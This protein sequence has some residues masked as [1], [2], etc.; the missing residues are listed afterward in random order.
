MI[1]IKTE[2]GRYFFSNF[3]N[4]K[5]NESIE[6][7][8]DS[9]G[10]DDLK[11]LLTAILAGRLVVSEEDKVVVERLASAPATSSSVSSPSLLAEDEKIDEQYIPYDK[12]LEWLNT[13]GLSSVDE[14]KSTVA[15]LKEGIDE[16]KTTLGELEITSGTFAARVKAVED[17]AFSVKR[18]TKPEYDRLSPIDLNDPKTLYLVM[19]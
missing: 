5:A 7:D 17:S 14:L 2:L 6:L 19:E 8:E 18:V 1:N 10:M 13:Q 11:Y 3:A 12:I 4:L 15:D 16:A 9:L